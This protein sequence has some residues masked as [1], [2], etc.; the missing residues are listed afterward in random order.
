M[1]QPRYLAA[2]VLGTLLWCGLFLAFTWIIDPYGVS[3]IHVSWSHVNQFKPKRLDIDRL[4]KPYEVW[5]YQ[6][7]T[8][9]L[10]T[11]RILQAID[12]SVLDGTAYAPAYNAS[13]PASSL[14]LNISHLRQYIDLDPQL[15]TVVVELFLYN[16]LGQEQEH[17][18]KT[19]AEYVRNTATLFASA[20]VLWASILTLGYNLIRN[21]PHYEIK[22]GGYFYYPPGHDAKGPFDGY[23]AGIWKLH[24]TRTEDMKL[25]EPA[26]DVVRE[27]IEI[28]R[29]HNLDL[30]FVLTPNHAYDDYYLESIDAWGTVQE[31]LS[32][33]SAEATVYSF[34]QP[35]AWVYEPVQKS[36]RYWNDPYHFS[37]EMGRAMQLALAGVKV[38]DAPNNF[39]VRMTPD[40]VPGHIKN[41]RETIRR[42]AQD[43]Q[44]FV[45]KF[46]EERRKWEIVQARDK[47]NKHG[48]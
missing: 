11:S 35:N 46:Q 24:E 4:I 9:F 37:L 18:P 20:D 26:F 19:L 5:R 47:R 27:I 45:A 44:D 7:R 6:P 15:R 17:A 8:V 25:H 10:G 29:E 14:G 16:F 42:W 23:P 30:V 12:P 41:R 28:C 32:R 48:S 38:D 33:V 21:V 31:W 36:M 39:M 2:F 43:N 22:P 13:I 3:P 40:M 1:A 34:S